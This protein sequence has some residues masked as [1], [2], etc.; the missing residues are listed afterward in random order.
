MKKE[1]K[2]YVKW[3]LIGKYICFSYLCISFAYFYRV[4]FSCVCHSSER[5]PFRIYEKGS[6]WASTAAINYDSVFFFFLHLHWR[7][8]TSGAIINFVRMFSF[9]FSD[10]TQRIFIMADNFFFMKMRNLSKFQCNK[11]SIYSAVCNFHW[12][13][14]ERLFFQYFLG[15]CKF[16]CLDRLC[17][18]Y[19]S[20][21]GFHWDE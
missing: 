18:K 1:N 2:N 11:T 8:S 20:C 17:I 7:D 15:I 5:H 4:R 19:F 14:E 6:V 16:S 10:E 21:S 13:K 9:I 3:I 12:E